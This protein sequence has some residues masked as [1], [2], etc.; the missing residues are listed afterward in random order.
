MSY[1]LAL[2]DTNIV[3]YLFRGDTRAQGYKEIIS[4]FR[5]LGISFQTLAELRYWAHS[6]NWGRRR[7]A[8]L[9]LHLQQYDLI[10]CDER[11]CDLWSVVKA[12]RAAVG[13]PIHPEDAWIAATALDLD[14]PLITHNPADFSAIPGL[15]VITDLADPS[16]F[17]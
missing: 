4:R 10:L 17:Q 15:R 16:P 2:V 6:A 3:S 14:C 5:F 1:E 12:Q 13:R 11:T 7:R 9:S 8:D